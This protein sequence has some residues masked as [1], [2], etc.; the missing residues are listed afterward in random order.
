MS[1]QKFRDNA[2]ALS[3]R[4][5][6]KWI[7]LGVK[8]LIRLPQ[9]IFIIPET[10]PFFFFLFSKPQL[11]TDGIYVRYAL[12]DF[13][14]E[15]ISNYALLWLKINKKYPHFSLLFWMLA[16]ATTAL[17]GKL[18]RVA[19]YINFY[20]QR[21]RLQINVDASALLHWEKFRSFHLFLVRLL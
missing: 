12:C 8:V 19:A 9:R 21:G 10:H 5:G 1:A 3:V 11:N 14:M 13:S 7:Q 15:T 18:K 4:T 6:S 20:F 16:I 2:I 17:H